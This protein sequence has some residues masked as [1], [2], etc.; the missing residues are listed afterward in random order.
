MASAAWSVGDAAITR[1]ADD[2]AA[3]AVVR[4]VAMLWTTARAR[5]TNV[6]PAGVRAMPRPSRA[7]RVRSS[8]RSSWRTARLSAGCAT[9]RAAAAAVML[10][11]SAV[12]T[13]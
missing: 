2:G 6:S 1:G 11:C 10:P 5:R 13:T 7:K 12:A 4:S 8:S 3:A 9:N